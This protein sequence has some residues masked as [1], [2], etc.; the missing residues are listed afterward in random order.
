MAKKI[1]GEIGLQVPA[2]KATPAP[3]IG[4]ALSQKGLNIMDFCKAFNAKTADMTPGMPI[5]VK[6]T[7][8]ADR[9]FTFELRQ[10]PVSYFLKT[11][12]GI[13]KGG[14][15]VGRGTFDGRV[16]RAQ[17]EEI[18]KKKMPDLKANSPE[19]AYNMVCGSA[20]SIGIEV[21]EG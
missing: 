9:T 6:I 1:V 7:A 8:Y 2:G 3:P 5:P 11:A 4:P 17:V 13:E 10:P 16:T 15:T 12:A 14:A 18:V 19:A 21:I 20:R